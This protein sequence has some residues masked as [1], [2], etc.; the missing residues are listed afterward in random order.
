M[1]FPYEYICPNLSVAVVGV[2]FTNHGPNFDHKLL[3][4]GGINERGR[5]PYSNIFVE[6]LTQTRE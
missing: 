1:Y 3:Y 5:F 2:I 4:S 6:T